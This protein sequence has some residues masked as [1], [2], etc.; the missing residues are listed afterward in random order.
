MAPRLT[1]A[2]RKVSCRTLSKKVLMQSGHISKDGTVTHVAKALTPTQIAKEKSRAL[3]AADGR[4][5]CK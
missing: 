1:A 4:A 3:A 2:S 5:G